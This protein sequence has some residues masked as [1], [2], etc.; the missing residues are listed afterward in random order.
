MLKEFGEESQPRYF[1]PVRGSRS[2]LIVLSFSLR[3]GL[4]ES[5]SWWHLGRRQKHFILWIWDRSWKLCFDS[6]YEKA[7]RNPGKKKSHLLWHS[8]VLLHST[9]HALKANSSKR[10][11]YALKQWSSDSLEMTCFDTK[12]HSLLL[13]VE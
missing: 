8:L 13:Q 5:S 11:V 4:R 10:Q 12:A 7:K 9:E 3:E 6:G 2:Y 1:S